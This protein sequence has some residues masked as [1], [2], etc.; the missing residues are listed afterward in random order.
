MLGIFKDPLYCM[1]L[2]VL[3]QVLSE[4]ITSCTTVELSVNSLTEGRNCGFDPALRKFSINCSLAHYVLEPILK[5][6][7]K[8]WDILFSLQILRE[9]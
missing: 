2:C 5:V 9:F 1:T 4:H 8:F 6:R 3:C 7:C